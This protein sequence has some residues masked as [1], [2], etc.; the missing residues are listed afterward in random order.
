[1]EDVQVFECTGSLFAIVTI[2][3]SGISVEYALVSGSGLRVLLLDG[4]VLAEGQPVGGGGFIRRLHQREFPFNRRSALLGSALPDR[5]PHLSSHRFDLF[6]F[7]H[8]GFY[9]V[10]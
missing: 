6:V 1:M 2:R 3:W 8:R 9:P 7:P 10:G 4:E 5:L